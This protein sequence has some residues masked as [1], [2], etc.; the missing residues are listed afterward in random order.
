MFN[1]EGGFLSFFILSTNQDFVIGLSLLLI[2]LFLAI[3]T[4]LL[5]WLAKNQSRKNTLKQYH[6]RSN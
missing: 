5:M 1:A 4:S 3:I 2:G 6:H